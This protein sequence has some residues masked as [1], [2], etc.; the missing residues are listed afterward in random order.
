MLP[1]GSMQTGTQC[2]D[3]AADTENMRGGEKA[4]D[5]LP[6]LGGRGWGGKGRCCT[7]DV[8]LVRIYLVKKQKCFPK[9]LFLGSGHICCMFRKGA[10]ITQGEKS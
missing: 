3:Q 2:S 9:L 5:S 10:K 4:F 8:Q 7:L 1:K 6:R